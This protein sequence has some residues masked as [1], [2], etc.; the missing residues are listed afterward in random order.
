VP[1][2]GANAGRSGDRI[3]QIH[4]G[5]RVTIHPVRVAFFVSP[6]YQGATLLALLLNNHSLISALGECSFPSRSF[7]IACAC[8]EFVNDCDFWQSVRLR[9]D[10]TGSLSFSTLLPVL[11][12]PLKRW[13]FEWSRIRL[14]P[15]PWLNRALGRSAARV[16]DVAAPAAWR[17]HPQLV[18][19]F[20]ESNR[21]LY[22]LV[23]EQHGTSVFVDGHKSWRKAALLARELIP[24]DDVRII[25]LVRDPRGFAVSQRRH[26]QAKRLVESA[27][28]WKDLHRH[29]RSLSTLA[30]YHL[31]RY[32]DLALRPEAEMQKVF[33]FL[34]LEGESV[35]GAPKI[36]AKHHIVG[37]DMVRGFDGEIRHDGRWRVELSPKEQQVVLAAAGPFATQLGYADASIA[38]PQAAI[39]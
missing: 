6:P 5:H 19:N 36:L 16:A 18:D 4:K 32:E 34:G 12:W 28:V 31:M 33:A 25:H 9:M 29:M 7:G 20:V 38:R 37:H 23:L 1:G 8:G 30:P 14:T 11:P 3:P 22:A 39:A 15:R 13:Q 21:S 26:G 2:R 35:V 24:S 10:P 27:W 17:L